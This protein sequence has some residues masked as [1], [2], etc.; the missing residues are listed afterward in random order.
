MT[1]SCLIGRHQHVSLSKE[2][3]AARGPVAR[4]LSSSDPASDGASLHATQL[5]NFALRQKPLALGAIIRHLPP[6]PSISSQQPSSATTCGSRT[7]AT[8]SGNARPT[9]SGPYPPALR[10]G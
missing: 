10:Q 9:S 8:A 6:P 7:V 4:D 5:R 3:A 1:G 2:Q